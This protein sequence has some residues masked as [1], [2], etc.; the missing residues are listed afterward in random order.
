[1]APVRPQLYLYS[2]ADALIPPE[3]VELFMK[4]QVVRQCMVLN[5]SLQQEY[6]ISAQLWL[7]GCQLA[8]AGSAGRPGLL[9]T[10]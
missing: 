2:S 8:H 6:Y 4:Q 1:M 5:P 10:V 7:T 3:D 9:K